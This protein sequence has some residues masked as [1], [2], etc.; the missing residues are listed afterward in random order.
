MESP[1]N[2]HHIDFTPRCNRKKSSFYDT[3]NVSGELKYNKKGI[4]SFEC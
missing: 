4:P 2:W 3:M 1:P